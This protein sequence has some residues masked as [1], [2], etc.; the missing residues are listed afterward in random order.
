MRKN[1]NRLVAFA[2]GISVM[3]GAAIPVFAADTTTATSNSTTAVSTQSTT[4]TGTVSGQT[5][6]NKTT[7]TGTQ[8]KVKPVLTLE[9]AINAGISNS[10]KLG[11]Q[12]KKINLEEDKLD[13]QDD[14]G[15]D[16]GY[17]Y[18]SQDLAVK[19]A[20]EDKEILEDQITQDV[21]DAYYEIV[22]SDKKLET[23]KKDLEIK[24]KEFK[25]SE[26]KQK[27]GLMTSTEIKTLEINLQTVKNSL[28]DKENTAKNSKDF[29]KVLT[30]KNLNDYILEQ[31]PKFEV[32]KIEGSVDE[33]LDNIVEKYYK[34]D[35]KSVELLKDYVKDIK[36]SRPS[37][38]P[39]SSDYSDD[40]DTTTGLVTKSAKDKYN[41]AMANYKAEM[42]SYQNY[43]ETRYN[44]SAKSVALDEN[45]KNT[46]Q[47]L[48]TNYAKLL[49]LE[50]TI[51]T[52]RANLE[53]N[54]KQLSI[55]K[56]K[57]DMGLVTKTEYNKQV[58]QSED[59]DTKLRADIDE[60]NKLKNK[61]RKPWL[62]G[63]MGMY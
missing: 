4:T 32:F 46:K 51:N 54:N 29:F 26:L 59:L 61:I 35:K 30:G 23:M 17:A 18:D 10:A 16:D 48:K 14:L 11:L 47:T 5:Q 25:D 42:A 62:A 27:L 7:I 39:S 58:L 63:S 3:S 1:I 44:S 20:K 31:D 43:L 6:T 15:N 41:D 57:Y 60:Y 12:K 52:D 13:I 33:Y 38:A 34:Y 56:L 45:K 8:I 21:T 2:I 40:V 49:N 24:T 19:E 37:E 22:A 28:Q 53:V 36:V 50:N 55:L 9:A